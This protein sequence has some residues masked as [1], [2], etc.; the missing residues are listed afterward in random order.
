M[1]VATEAETAEAVAGATLEVAAGA[2]QE[3]DAISM[4]PVIHAAAETLDLAKV[5]EVVATEPQV[6]TMQSEAGAAIA[7]S[8]LD[9]ASEVTAVAMTVDLNRAEAVKVVSAV[10]VA[11]E[12]PAAIVLHVAKAVSNETSNAAVR[13]DPNET[14]AAVTE[15]RIHHDAI[16]AVVQ[17]QPAAQVVRAAIRE[18]SPLAMQNPAKPRPLSEP[19]KSAARMPSRHRP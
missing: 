7:T 10:A 18:P 1:A 19:S 2:I 14:A 5:T 11:M 3:A 9:A 16:A 6:S 4:V 8:V 13:T 12:A 17:T 15:V